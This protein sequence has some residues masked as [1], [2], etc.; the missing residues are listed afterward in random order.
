MSQQKKTPE[1]RNPE[2]NLSR[3]NQEA[4]WG[5][6]SHFGIRHFGGL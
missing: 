4:M 1:A 3:P 2:V 5:K 6:I